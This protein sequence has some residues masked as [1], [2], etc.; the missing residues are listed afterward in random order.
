VVNAKVCLSE[1]TGFEGLH[2]TATVAAQ[3][4][5][6]GADDSSGQSFQSAALALLP[7]AGLC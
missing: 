3:K 2:I 6:L 1:A 7:Q 4:K 5:N